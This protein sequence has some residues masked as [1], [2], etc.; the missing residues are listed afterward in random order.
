MVN[1]LKYCLLI[2]KFNMLKVLNLVKLK[3]NMTTYISDQ[4][5]KTIYQG[6]IIS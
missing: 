1:I 4:G 3:T 2:F 5:H 6:Y